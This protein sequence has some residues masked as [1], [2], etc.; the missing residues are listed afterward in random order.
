[1]EFVDGKPEF[2]H[3][4]DFYRAPYSQFRETNLS[5]ENDKWYWAMMAVDGEGQYRSLVWEDGNPAN[6]AFCQE[7]SRATDNNFNFSMGFG[8]N[9]TLNVYEYFIIDFDGF[10]DMDANQ[11][12]GD[13]NQGDQ[14][15]GNM[16]D[17]SQIISEILNDVDVLYE[18]S[19]NT[20]PET[21]YTAYSDVDEKRPGD[22]FEFITRDSSDGFSFLTPLM[23]VVPEGHRKDNMCQA[24]LVAFKTSDP[25]GVQFNLRAQEAPFM[26]FMNGA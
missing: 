8:P 4:Q 7:G 16:Q 22:G 5:L 9:M 10:T 14:N 11:N 1:M 15:Q 6:N 26:T 12:Q 2:V 20:F 23:D 3:V 13:Q 19:L 24:V 17:S 25:T 18:D 21:G